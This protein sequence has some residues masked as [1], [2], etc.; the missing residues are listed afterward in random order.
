MEGL[1]CAGH[2]AQCTCRDHLTASSQPPTGRSIVIHS[3]QMRKLRLREVSVLFKAKRAV[4]GGA[5]I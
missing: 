2:C 5:Q 1:L 3:L 4:D